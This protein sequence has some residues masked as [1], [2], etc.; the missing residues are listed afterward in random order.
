MEKE[1]FASWFDTSYY[2]QLYQHRN[3]DEAERFITNLSTF[4]QLPLG[5]KVLDL[6]CGKGR[7]S[8]TLH[9]L[10]YTV[11]GVDLSENSILSAKVHEQANLTFAV[12]DM[13]L[14][15]P[16][17]F[18]A[19]FN[20]FTSFGYFDE[21]AENERV[22]AAISQMLLPNGVLVIDFMN[23][24]KVI[25]NL[26]QEE[27]K[28]VGELDF[29]ISRY[30]T[31]SHIYKE[32]RFSDKDQDFHFTERVQALH[33]ADFERLLQNDFQLMHTFG[34]FDLEPFHP[35]LS[36]RLIIVARKK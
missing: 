30:N 14:V 7:H 11:T 18:D 10:G 28:K 35:E 17:A 24:H 23:A 22:C 15:Y 16:D 33:L 25:Q 34:N 36:D 13:R 2:H 12:H 31:T 27:V 9:Q 8:R 19:V 26:V 1:W 20:L 6:A 32:I 5:S 4:L 29:H 3:E 21:A